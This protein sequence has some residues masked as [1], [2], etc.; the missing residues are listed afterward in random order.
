[1]GVSAGSSVRR[2]R[3]WG[4]PARA[5]LRHLFQAVDRGVEHR[6]TFRRRHLAPRGLELARDVQAKAAPFLEGPADGRRDAGFEYLRLA[7][8]RLGAAG[9]RLT[10]ACPRGGAAL[11]RS[12][13]GLRRR[14]RSRSAW[15]SPAARWS[16]LAAVNPSLARTAEPSA[17]QSMAWTSKT[18]PALARRSA[19]ISTAAA[20]RSQPTHRRPSA[21]A[22][23][24]A[25]PEPQKKSATRPPGATRPRRCA[26]AA[27]P[28]SG[29]DSRCAQRRGRASCRECRTTRRRAGGGR[30][31]GRPPPV[32]ST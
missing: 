16:G 19:A 8:Q 1:M 28:A 32:G 3:L 15:R 12:A 9:G 22:A 11:P 13:R 29:W 17:D 5:L 23:A 27:A 2:S 18:A 26:A 4:R 24:S 20:L 21:S 31:R 30:R 25:V 6:L 10:R 7:L 14:S